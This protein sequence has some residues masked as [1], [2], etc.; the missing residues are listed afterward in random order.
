ML[1]IVFNDAAGSTAQ[2]MSQAL[3]LQGM[4][5]ADVNNENAA[6]QAALVNPDPKIALTV[7]SSLWMHLSSNSV[8]PAFTQANAT[9]YGAEVADLAGAPANVN[10]WISS[11][12][13]CRRET[14]RA[15]SPSS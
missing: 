1:Q 13:S 14:M 15:T 2:A 5:V 8:L 4:S 12:A 7:A 10:T 9:Y 11:P 6:L 3:Q